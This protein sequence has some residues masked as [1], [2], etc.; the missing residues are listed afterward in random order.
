GRPL[1]L[2]A[3]S[4]RDR[5]KRR[6]VDVSAAQWHDDPVSLVE[7]DADV[8][9]EL[10][11][12]EDGAAY[13]LVRK[14]LAAGKHVVTANKALL[15][16]HGAELAALAEEHHVALKFEAAAAGGIAIVQA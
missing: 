2:V 11:G 1:E 14:A 8:I 13:A 12:G 15:A 10:V 5:K 16:H 7:S 6:A 3:V 9:V 4:A